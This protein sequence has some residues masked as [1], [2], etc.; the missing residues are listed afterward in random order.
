MLSEIKEEIIEEIYAIVKSYG[1]L[2]EDITLEKPKNKSLGD[3]ALPCFP[4]AKVMK[5]SPNQIAT[6]IKNEMNIDNYEKIDVVNGYL[7]IFFNRKRIALSILNK[8]FKLKNHYGDL[9]IGNEKTIVIDYSAPNIAKPFSVGHLRSTVIGNSLRKVLMKLGY[10]VI[11]INHLGDWGTQFGKLIYAYKTW[12]N[13][14]KVMANP[15]EEL[16]LL[17]VKFHQEAENNPILD[18]KAR[19]WFKKLEDKDEEAIELWQWFKDV[20]IKSYMDMYDLLGIDKFDSY[21]GESFY[22]DKMDAIVDELQTKGLLKLDDG[23]QIVH[24]GEDIAPALIKRSDG[25]SLYITRDLAAALYRKKEY[26]FDEAL[27]VVGSEQTLHFIQ[28]KKVLNKMN[29]VWH[30]DIHHIGFGMILQD[31]KKMS[32]RHG[33]TAKLIDVLNDAT[34]L[35]EKY[36][37]EKNSSLRNKKEISKMVGIGAV[38]FNDLKTNRQNDVDFDLENILKFEGE[39]SPYISYTYARIK[40]LLNNVNINQINNININ[41]SDYIWDIILQLLEF[42]QTIILTKQ[43]YDP[44]LIAKYLI[45]LAQSFNRLYAQE[46]IISDDAEQTNLKGLLCESVSIILKEG[47]SLLGIKIPNEM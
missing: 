13:K 10:K 5:Q 38:I 33:K 26:D 34:K 24:L 8:I 20:S 44:S 2:K 14:E 27:Y 4:L 23:A 41:I 30:S 15:I 47:M 12:G 9:S 18:D 11:G 35:A 1:V 21:D 22:N 25:A 3:L 37:E 39:T 45:D 40:S 46:K 43:N 19:E 31:G 6:T 17:Y 7:N 16:N 36:I 29:Y 28:L 42:E 32:T